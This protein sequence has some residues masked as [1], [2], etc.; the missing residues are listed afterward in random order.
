MNGGGDVVPVWLQ[1]ALELLFP[2]NL[3]A[4]AVLFAV[5]VA[6]LPMLPT[7]QG[8]GI[9][10]LPH[11]LLLGLVISY[12]SSARGTPT[13]M[14]CPRWPLPPSQRRR[15]VG[16]VQAW[17]SQYYPDDPL[18]VIADTGDAGEK[19]L[20]L[21]VS[22]LKPSAEEPA[23]GNISDDATDEEAEFLISKEGTGYGG[24]REH[25]MSSPSS[26]LDAG[27]TLQARPRVDRQ[28][29]QLLLVDPLRAQM[30]SG[31]VARHAV[32]V[33]RRGRRQRR[34]PLIHLTPVE[35]QD[36]HT[37]SIISFSSDSLHRHGDPRPVNL[38]VGPVT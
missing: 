3:A 30:R 29:R 28:V 4:K 10:D 23:P 6:L 8:L 1:W 21:P 22:K 33:H 37:Q 36:P 27:L 2:S 9:W 7:S 20:L 31:D 26:V 13:P 17:S 12:G 24:A 25:A 5:V 32:Q 16:G 14:R 34:P 18:V 15:Q 19:P 38:Q 35:I 11:I